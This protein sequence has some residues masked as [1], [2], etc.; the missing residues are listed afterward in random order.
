[1]ND[2]WFYTK[3]YKSLYFYR[4]SST[5]I[6]KSRTYTVSNNI[7]IA[8]R[9]PIKFAKKTVMLVVNNP[10]KLGR[11]LS[12]KRTIQNWQKDQEKLRIEYK[13]W[14][15]NV[16]TPSVDYSKQRKEADN[17]KKKPLISL[18]TPVFNPPKDAHIKLVESVLNQTYGNFELLLY[19]F[20]SDPA[21]S[22]L[23][24]D[25][26]KMD[27][28]IRV[29]HDLPNKGISENSNLC[30]EDVGGEYIGLLDHDD[31]LMPNALF[32]CM[33]AANDNDADFI[34][35]DK[36]KITED[37]ER[38]DPLFKPDWS[39]EMALGGNYM[40]HFNL[41]RTKLVKE[42]GGW[43]KSTDGAQDWDLF[44]RI[45]EITDKIVHVPKILYHWRIVE[46]ST[47]NGIGVKPYAMQ[48]QR[49][50]VAK[51]LKKLNLNATPQHDEHGQLNIYW[52]NK[53][54]KT[55]AVIKDGVNDTN[56]VDLLCKKIMSDE[57]ITDALEIA[58]F[59]CA[60][61]LTRS[62]DYKTIGRKIKKIQYTSGEFSSKLSKYVKENNYEKIVYINSTVKDDISEDVFNQILGWLE[63][64]EVNISSGTLLSEN[65][66]VSDMGS[67]IDSST[68]QFNKYHFA[69]GF[70]S[71]YLGFI[72]WIRNFVLPAENF[73]A[74]DPNLIILASKKVDLSKI[75]D[76][77]FIKCLALVN[78]VEGGRTVYDPTV[79]LYDK[80]PFEI[81]LPYSS[82]LDKF[83]NANNKKL[84]KDPYYNENLDTN[85]RDPKPRFKSITAEPSLYGVS[86]VDAHLN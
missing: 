56:S 63:I 65:G 48:G 45:I 32:E 5:S 83:V 79:V 25:Y 62:L 24:D 23:L 26:S 76:D 77:E 37:D 61:N 67:F 40:T 39:P 20:G 28:R 58:I 7:R 35:S 3:L 18:I 10:T 82:E 60:E 33:K 64:P 72:Q 16:E 6:V 13:N 53:S 15:K 22:K 51:H 19:D 4:H 50:A 42:L 1:M 34:Y 86:S 74:I 30:L 84:S 66:Q 47:A 49:N 71:G 52:E 80:A 38:F 9:E 11:I 73:C 69:T 43:D 12:G 41:M 27:K 36:D 21:I 31:A 14:I 81:R 8:I 46:N 2:S 17:L 55:L 29:K 70:R 78:Y 54:K 85:Y 68:I 57:S 75:R 44:F 59:Y